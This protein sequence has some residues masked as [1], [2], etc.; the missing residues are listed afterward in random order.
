VGKLSLSKFRELWT[1]VGIFAPMTSCDLLYKKVME[2]IEDT[3]EDLTAR[4]FIA[5]YV[6]LFEATYRTKIKVE[7]RD[8][9]IA[10]AVIKD[11]GCAQAI[12]LLKTY[13]EMK[14]QFFVSRTHDL[15]TFKANLKKIQV[16]AQTGTAVTHKQAQQMEQSDANAEAI[17]KYLFRKYGKNG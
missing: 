12:N 2:L 8:A 1:E 9:G 4:D 13:F 17:K 14:D 16:K 6:D 10:K 5:T 15:V 7:G 3:P 11:L